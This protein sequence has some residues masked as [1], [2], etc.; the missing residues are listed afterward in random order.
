MITQDH[1]KF[2]EPKGAL[3]RVVKLN[4]LTPDNPGVIDGVS[5]TIVFC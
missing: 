2:H 3:Q 4:T 1:E 5:G